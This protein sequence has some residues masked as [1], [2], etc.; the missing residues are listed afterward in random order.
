MQ[1]SNQRQCVPP[2]GQEREAPQ[3]VCLYLEVLGTRLGP[4]WRKVTCG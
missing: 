1:V 2:K 3:G 4:L